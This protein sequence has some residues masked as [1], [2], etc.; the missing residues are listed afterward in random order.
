MTSDKKLDGIVRKTLLTFFHV[1]LTELD[2][3]KRMAILQEADRANREGR[4]VT[5]AVEESYRSLRVRE[6]DS[7]IP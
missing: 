2:N 6:L 5:D 1:H 7:E 3:Q 4:N